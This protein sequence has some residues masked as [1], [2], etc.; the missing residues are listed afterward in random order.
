MKKLILFLILFSLA[1][2]AAAPKKFTNDVLQFGGGSNG[3][4]KELIFDTGAGTNPSIRANS[5]DGSLLLR[6]NDVSL[7][8]GAASDKTLS[9]DVGAGANNPKLFWDNAAGALSFSNDGTLIKKIGSG[10]G[11]GGSG[12]VNLLSNSSFEDPG[13]PILNWTNSGGTLTQ[14]AHTNG[15]EDNLK[16]ARFVATGAAQYVES[17]TVTVSDD[18]GFGCMADV[19]YNQGDN[20]FTLK[21]L[22]EDL[23]GNPGTFIDVA[24]GDFSDL[25]AFLKAPTVTFPCEGGDV[26]KLRFES[27]GAGTIDLEDAYL[28]SNKN[29][30]PVGKGAHFVGS[31]EW[32]PTT[33][34][35]WL[36]GSTSYIGGY[37]PDNDCDDNLRIITGNITD[38]QAG[39]RPDF[40]INFMRKGHYQIV[41][42]GLFQ[43]NTGGV[44]GTQISHRLNVN[45][46][47]FISQDMKFFDNTSG[48]SPVKVFSINTDQD[49]TNAQIVLESKTSNGS[50]AAIIEATDNSFKYD[51]YYFPTSQETQEAFTPEQA[52]FTK[53]DAIIYRSNAADASNASSTFAQISLG[54]TGV[55]EGEGFS[56]LCAGVEQPVGGNCATDTIFGFRYNIPVSGK[57]EVCVDGIGDGNGT[58]YSTKLVMVSNSNSGLIIQDKTVHSSGNSSNWDGFNICELFEISSIGEYSFAVYGATNGT[59]FYRLSNSVGNNSNDM[60][61]GKFS[62]SPVKNDVATPR[63][64]NQVSTR[65]RYGAERGACFLLNPSGTPSFDS[66]D[67]DCWFVDS[68]SF[69][70]T[71]IFNLNLTEPGFKCG[72]S[73]L[74]GNRVVSITLDDNA[75]VVTNTLPQNV[76]IQTRNTGGATANESVSIYCSRNK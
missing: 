16:Y 12:G 33:S 37:G 26:F 64:L 22:K 31:I 27:T 53:K 18:L 70:S 73:V 28:G 56:E 54:N 13:S 2:F 44:T 11:S 23:P 3:S 57:V 15:R 39:L 4:I 42:T 24:S 49:L 9:F 8:D 71:G 47:Q 74:G 32:Q 76:R 75:S 43:D 46:G 1:V 10:S 14:E 29:I 58:V 62:I 59:A 6:P 30:S 61:T 38:Y 50:D 21:V 66:S 65:A 20:A 48:G 19:K 41:A 45:G 25:T 60:Q 51:V 35:Q 52:G 68:L 40:Q 72:V 7:G 67:P 17:D 69:D 55:I 36:D 63:L 34:C 5:G